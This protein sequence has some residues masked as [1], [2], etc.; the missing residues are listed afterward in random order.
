MWLYISCISEDSYRKQVVIDG[1]TC[2]LDILDTAGQEEYRCVEMIGLLRK[3]PLWEVKHDVRV[4]NF[5]SNFATRRGRGGVNIPAVLPKKATVSFPN[6]EGLKPISHDKQ[7]L[8][9][10]DLSNSFV[11]VKFLF[12]RISPTFQGNAC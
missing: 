5:V 2:L 3:R 9:W 6:S 12:G 11:P 7:Y 8:R 10:T 4:E 1:E